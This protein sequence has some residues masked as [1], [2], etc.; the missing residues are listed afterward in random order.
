MR[1]T[2]APIARGNKEGRCEGRMLPLRG[3]IEMAGE[4]EAAAY[5]TRG[6]WEGRLRG[7][8]HIVL[9]RNHNFKTMNNKINITM[10]T[11]VQM[12]A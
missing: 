7:R 2:D 11:I 6:Q 9:A 12:R 8:L 5:L 4:E 10:S 1:G 3:G